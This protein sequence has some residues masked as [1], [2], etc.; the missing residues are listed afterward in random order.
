[1]NHPKPQTNKYSQAGR[2]WTEVD[3]MI[4]LWREPDKVQGEC[5]AEPLEVRLAI[6]AR[7]VPDRSGLPCTEVWN[8]FWSI[9]NAKL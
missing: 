6:G 2:P 5:E 9:I 3:H 8:D 4:I 7:D 1:V